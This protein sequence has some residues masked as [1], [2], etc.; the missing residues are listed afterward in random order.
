[1]I[2]AFRLSAPDL[3]PLSAPIR[4]DWQASPSPA[5]VSKRRAGE[6]YARHGV[7]TC[8]ASPIAMCERVSRSQ[9]RNWRAP[10]V[11]CRIQ[12]FGV[13]RREFEIRTF[14]IASTDTLPEQKPQ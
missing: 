8:K 2:G 11:P 4:R 6:W 14:E 7:L 12:F 9:G 5:M 10:A 3:E 1:M 13:F